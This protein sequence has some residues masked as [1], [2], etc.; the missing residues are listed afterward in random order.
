ME[1]AGGTT[2]HALTLHRPAS[3]ENEGAGRGFRRAPRSLSSA[4]CPVTGARRSL[5]L[6][7]Q[8]LTSAVVSAKLAVVLVQ[9]AVVAGRVLLSGVEEAGGSR[10]GTGGARTRGVGTTRKRRGSGRASFSRRRK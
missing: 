2:P 5:E 4:S 7:S 6:I 3:P 10:R 1:S 8:P 9:L